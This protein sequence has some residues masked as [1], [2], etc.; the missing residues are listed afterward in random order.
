MVKRLPFGKTVNDRGRPQRFPTSKNDYRD[1]EREV[2]FDTLVS[3]TLNDREQLQ[4]TLNN[5]K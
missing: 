3:I 4:T 2:V 5:N 1:H